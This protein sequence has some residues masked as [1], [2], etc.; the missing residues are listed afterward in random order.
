M[1]DKARSD[2][3]LIHLA[4]AMDV[5]NASESD[6]TIQETLMALET[7]RHGFTELLLVKT[8]QHRQFNRK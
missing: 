3:L 2:R 6:L 4:K 7:L 8:K 5:F 1:A